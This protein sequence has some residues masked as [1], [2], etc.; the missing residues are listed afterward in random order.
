LSLPPKPFFSSPRNVIRV[1]AVVLLAAGTYGQFMLHREPAPAAES[2]LYD[3]A[4]TFTTSAGAT[5]QRVQV[6]SG[7]TINVSAADQQGKLQAAF[8]LTEA[9]A[10]AVKL[11]GGFGCSGASTPTAPFTARLGAP[12]A[13]KAKADEG[14]PPCAL[15]MV[16]TKLAEAAPPK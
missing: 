14:A 8:V 13:I 9:G 4:M 11:D 12:A 16:V 2:T 10:D 15:E 6:R 1:V 5:P 7:Q 3:V